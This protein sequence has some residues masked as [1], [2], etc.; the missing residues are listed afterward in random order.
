MINLMLTGLET[1]INRVLRLDPDTLEKLG[2]LDG[3][4]VK[5]E[6]A[7][8]ETAFYVLPYRQGLQLVSD[9]HKKPDTIIKGK[10]IN[11]VKVGTA[12]VTTAAMFDESI[13]ISGDTRTGEAIRHVFKNLDI[14]W[15]EHLSKMVGDTIAHKLAYHFKKTLTFGKNSIRSLGENIQEYVHHE[16]K[17]FPTPDAVEH[18]YQEVGTLRDDMDRIEARVIR[19]KLNQKQGEQQ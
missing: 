11:L 16:S 18:F 19:L 5:I 3:K 2:E 7:D 12:G 9:Y 10:L 1:A 17:Q 4:A 13:S 15:E 6:L 8:W 14:D